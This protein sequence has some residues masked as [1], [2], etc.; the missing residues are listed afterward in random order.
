MTG[1]VYVVFFIAIIIIGICWSK[2]IITHYKSSD[3]K[4]DITRHEWKAG[5]SLQHGDCQVNTGDACL[6]NENNDASRVVCKKCGFKN[7]K[8]ATKCSVCGHKLWKF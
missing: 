4:Q 8:S 7:E 5:D 2:E 1:V 3:K 6:H